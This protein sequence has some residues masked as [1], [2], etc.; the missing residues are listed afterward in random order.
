MVLNRSVKINK[1]L[2]RPE[3]GALMPFEDGRAPQEEESS[4][5]GRAQP[6]RDYHRAVN[7]KLQNLHSSSGCLL[8]AGLPQ[9]FTPL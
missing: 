7:E 3:G 1:T 5:Q 6:M 9:F 2:N 4:W 8:T